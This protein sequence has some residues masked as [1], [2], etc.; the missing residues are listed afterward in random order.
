MNKDNVILVLRAFDRMSSEETLLEK[1]MKDMTSNDDT[2]REAL[3]GN[4]GIF[5]LLLAAAKEAGISDENIA[6]FQNS[7]NTELNERL[8]GLTVSPDTERLNGIM[9]ALINNIELYKNYPDIALSAN[10]EYPNER[11]NYEINQKKA[12][13]TY[14][15]EMVTQ[16]RRQLAA[17]YEYLKENT[18]H[19]LGQVVFEGYKVLFNAADA[20]IPG[21]VSDG[22]SNIA[23]A[24]GFKD[25]DIKI[26][27]IKLQLLGLD[28]NKKIYN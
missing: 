24:M 26:I 16:A 4:N 21:D 17:Q 5:T 15:R 10:S 27:I 8:S 14:A 1:I 22:L 19:N 6:K 7:F 28:L 12:T 23:K 9:A 25:A 3:V 18:V 11:L 13:V 2:M 20:V